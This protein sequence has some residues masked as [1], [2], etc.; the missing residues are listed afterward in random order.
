MIGVVAAPRSDISGRPKANASP[1]AASA[2]GIARQRAGLLDAPAAA[3][4][5]GAGCWCEAAVVPAA[6][7]CSAIRASPMS[8][9]R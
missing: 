5:A 2:H 6:I 7:S 4:G 8:R 3:A 1:S 9:S